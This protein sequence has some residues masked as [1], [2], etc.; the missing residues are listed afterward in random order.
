MSSRIEETV[1]AMRR[2][3]SRKSIAHLPS[4][5]KGNAIDKENMTADVGALSG[6]QKGQKNGERPGK[7]SRSKSIGPGGV[8]ALLETTGNRRQVI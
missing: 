8:D 5:E 3:K 2:P 7:K 6:T 4:A 1:P